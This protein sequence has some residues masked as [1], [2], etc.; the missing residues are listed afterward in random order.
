MRFFIELDRTRQENVRLEVMPYG[1]RYPSGSSYSVYNSSD[2][3]SSFETKLNID[4]LN[5]PISRCCSHFCDYFEIEE[6]LK[7]IVF[8]LT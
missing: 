8:R 4:D 7:L 6:N 5:G 2:T 1:T 3:F